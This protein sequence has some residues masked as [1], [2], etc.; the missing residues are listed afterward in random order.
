[1][2]MNGYDVVMKKA[3][4]AELK[5][6]L[7]HYLRAVRRGETVTVLDRDTPIAQIVPVKQ[8]ALQ[9]REPIPGSPPPNRIPLLP[10]LELEFDILDLLMEERQNHR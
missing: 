5:A 9:V 4:V 7:S 2:T 8:P 1:M 3:G 10:P 6:R